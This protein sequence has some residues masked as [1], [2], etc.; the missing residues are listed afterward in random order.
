VYLFPGYLTRSE[1]FSLSLDAARNEARIATLRSNEASLRARLIVVIYIQN[2][3][4]FSAVV[5]RPTPLIIGTA[6]SILN[7][8]LRAR[9][10]SA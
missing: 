5:E 8:A 9:D 4:L 1:I 7:S 3:A 2:L 6:D 10:R